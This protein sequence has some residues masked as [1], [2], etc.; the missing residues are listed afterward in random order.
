MS[1]PTLLFCR[2]AGV[3]ARTS[4]QLRS[5]L[6]S[7]NAVISSRIQVKRY[8]IYDLPSATSERT[9]KGGSDPS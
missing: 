8:M 1:T 3:L 5:T 7:L 4:A 6:G 2:P 9:D